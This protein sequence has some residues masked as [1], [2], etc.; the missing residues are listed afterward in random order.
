M[1]YNSQYKQ[2]CHEVFFY[3]PL[4]FWFVTGFPST[5][6]CILNIKFVML[7]NNQ[8]GGEE[9]QPCGCICAQYSPGSFSEGKPP[10][11]QTLKCL[12]WN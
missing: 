10:K 8:E 4:L 6:T 9:H 7:K 5:S 12:N 3:L 11:G 2:I 1:N